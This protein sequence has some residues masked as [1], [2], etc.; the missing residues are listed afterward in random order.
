[1]RLPKK[2]LSLFSFFA[3]WL[4]RT[5]KFLWLLSLQIGLRIWQCILWPYKKYAPFDRRH[6]FRTALGVLIL[7]NLIVMPWLIWTWLNHRLGRPI[8]ALLVGDVGCIVN[9]GLAVDRSRKLFPVRGRH[10]LVSLSDVHWVQFLLRSLV[11]RCFGPQSIWMWP[12]RQHCM[13]IGA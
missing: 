3:H 11:G 12:S 2:C 9:C 4:T 10:T 8:H 5:A 7:P 6:G 13:E 1:M